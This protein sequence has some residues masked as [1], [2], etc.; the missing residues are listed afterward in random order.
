MSHPLWGD[1]PEISEVRAPQPLPGPD[2][3]THA[4]R[5]FLG[6]PPEKTDP[7]LCGAA[8]T[9]AY[10]FPGIARPPCPDCVAAMA[11]VVPASCEPQGR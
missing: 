2:S 9:D 11:V 7:P 5:T 6:L 8:L 10:D 4:F 3:F 1:L